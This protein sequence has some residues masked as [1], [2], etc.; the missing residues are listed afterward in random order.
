MGLLVEM[1]IPVVEMTQRYPVDD[2][3]QRTPCELQ[4]RHK[5]LIFTVAF[6][7]T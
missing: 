6:G 3:T 2:I 4:S 1:A 7:I 5:N